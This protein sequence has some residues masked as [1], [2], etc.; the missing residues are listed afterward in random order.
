MWLSNKDAL[1]AFDHAI[2]AQ[3]VPFCVLNLISDIDG[4][5]WDMTRTRDIIGFVPR[6]SYRPS[7]SQTD[8][9]ADR[10]ARKSTLQPGSWLDQ[11]FEK[12]N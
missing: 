6:D 4:T 9:E 7:L 5:R 10:L 12:L 8:I 2:A 3:N 11:F 1:R